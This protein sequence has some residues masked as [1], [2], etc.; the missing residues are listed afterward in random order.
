[1]LPEAPKPAQAGGFGAAAAPFGGGAFG[2]KPAA[3]GALPTQP[4]AGGAFGAQPAASAQQAVDPAK[5]AAE[6]VRAE[7]PKYFTTEHFVPASGLDKK[8]NDKIRIKQRP[9]ILERKSSDGE[10]AFT[11]YTVVL[12]RAKYAAMYGQ[13]D[14]QKVWMVSPRPGPDNLF[15]MLAILAIELKVSVSSH[16]C[17]L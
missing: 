8:S 4:A 16:N 17:A 7:K 13:P 3:F 2:A 9:L 15:Q 11:H 14:A 12:D 1:M 10:R 5:K 6:A